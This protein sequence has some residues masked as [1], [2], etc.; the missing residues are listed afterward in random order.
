MPVNYQSL[1]L[2]MC[3]CGIPH[4]CNRP[5]DGKP[6]ILLYCCS[7]TDTHTRMHIHIHMHTHACCTTAVGYPKFEGINLPPGV[8]LSGA[9]PVH[10]PAVAVSAGGGAPGASPY[11]YGMPPGAA[12]MPGA[13]AGAAPAAA[14]GTPQPPAAGQ[15]PVYGYPPGYPQQGMMPGQQPPMQ[16]QQQQQPL[17]YPPGVAMPPG[18]AASVQGYRVVPGPGGVPVSQPLNMQ[19]QPAG[20]AAPASLN[21]MEQA[22]GSAVSPVPGA[23]PGPDAV[24][25]IDEMAFQTYMTV[26]SQADKDHDGFVSGT[27]LA[28]CSMQLVP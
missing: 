23:S 25:E 11:V 1:E 9:R 10:T 26:F 3:P 7:F 16:Q 14:A 4:V 28:T 13:G 12:G 15:Y 27:C 24:W 17:N 8:P 22:R 21:P 20:L 18:A 5:A 19:P 2:R 6:V